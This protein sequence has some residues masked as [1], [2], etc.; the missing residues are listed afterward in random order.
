MQHDCISLYLFIKGL[1]KKK[2]GRKMKILCYG[3]RDVEKPIFEKVNERFHFDLTLAPYLL[4]DE[5]VHDV[6]GHDALLLRA[7]CKADRKNLEIIK[8]TYGIEYVLTRTAGYNHIDLEAAKELGIRVAYVPI[9]SPNAISELAV[10]LTMDLARHS[11]YAASRTATLDFSI[12]GPMF[13]KEIRNS[14]VGIIGLGNIGLTTAKLF[15]GLG[16]TIVGNDIIEKDVDYIEQLPLDELAKRSDIVIVH[17]PYFPGQ[18]DQ[19]IGEDFINNMNDGG[20][21]VNVA[22]GELQDVD[23]IVKA[24]KSGKLAGFATDVVAAEAK[25][26]GKTFNDKTELLPEIQ[27]LTALYPRVLVTPHIGS[28]TDEA[29]KNMVEVSFENIEDIKSGKESKRIL[30]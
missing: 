5:N 2:V 17:C 13:S 25:T 6:A 22:R 8:N 10:A 16:A 15:H 30:A 20:I 3:V 14:V 11:L 26:F 24:V 23:A 29:V 4:N 28:Y 7:N 18:N 21:I 9:Y 1:T 27:A 12:D 19:L